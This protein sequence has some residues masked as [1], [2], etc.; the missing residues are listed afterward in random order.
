MNA[1]SLAILHTAI[2]DAWAA[3]DAVAVGTRLDGSLRR[4]PEERTLDNKNKAISYAAY[5]VLVDLY[6][7]RKTFL[8]LE[9]GSLG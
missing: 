7:A 6:P 2:F 1:R 9:L 3:Y 8:D 5:D 4:P